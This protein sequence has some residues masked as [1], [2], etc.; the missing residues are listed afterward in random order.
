MK[1]I[2]YTI[3][4]AFSQL[5]RNKNMSSASI[6]AIMAMMI[7]LGIFFTLMVN[8]NLMV[9]NAED[10]F[11]T[12]QFYLYDNVTDE[13]AKQMVEKIS[14]MEHVTD[15]EYITKEEAMTIMK[16]RWGEKSYLLEGLSG[17]PFPASIEITADDIKYEEDLVDDVAAMEGIEEVKFYKE[18]INKL[19]AITGYIQTGALILIGILIIVSI[20]VVS[21]TIKLTVHAREREIHIMKYVG[22]TNWFIR[23]PFLVEGMIIGLIASI[24][25]AAIVGV[26]YYKFVDIFSSKILIMFNS[27]MVPYTFII[28]NSVII[29]IA[30]GISIGALGSI[31]SMR[32]FLKA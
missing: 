19:L 8:V 30:L 22:A 7:I 15:A 24:L 12:I 23:G 10:Q 4:Q 21:N 13:Q 11:D 17:N 20:I 32:R 28:Q 2:S 18:V 27:G 25:A 29:F 16:E 26:T 31:L 1:A 6:F 5:G 9:Q 3:K 14:K